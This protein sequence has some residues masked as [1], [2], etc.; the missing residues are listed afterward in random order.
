MMTSKL[1]RWLAVRLI[2]PN[3]D[4]P[5]KDTENDI[6]TEDRAGGEVQ[7]QYVARQTGKWG[8]PPPTPADSSLVLLR[9]AIGQHV[10]KARAKTASLAQSGSTAAAEWV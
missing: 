8:Q 2:C 4:G 9:N 1:C 7:K 6:G 10:G 3:E 5:Q